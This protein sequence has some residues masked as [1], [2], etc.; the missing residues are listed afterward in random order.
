M[1]IS[2]RFCMMISFRTSGNPS[3]SS[4]GMLSGMYRTTTAGEPFWRKALMRKLPTPSRAK[5]VFISIS[6]SYSLTW[7]SV[8]TSYRSWLTVSGVIMVWLT[9]TSWPLILMLI[10]APT[11]MK[12]SDAFL[13]AMI[14]NSLFIADISAPLRLHVLIQ[15]HCT[16]IAPE[17]I[18]QAGLGARL[19]VDLFYYHRTIQAV[20]A[21]RR[22]NTSGNHYRA[23]RHPAV[24]DLPGGAVQDA[25]ALAEEDA[26]GNDAVL[27]D[28]DAFDHLRARPDEAVVLD[29]HRI[30]LHRLEHAA[31]SHAARQVHVLADLGAGAHRRPGID[32][33]AFIDVGPDIDEGGHEDDVLRDVGAS[34][35]R[36]RRDDTE[37]ALLE[38][39][40]LEF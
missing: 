7:R 15:I 32:H 21:A 31:D 2:P 25:G 13:S 12:M 10:G 33:R 40:G 34:P 24:Q 36:G 26:H 29:D 16:L 20:F 28:D 14:W 9:G 5:A 4:G 35:G 30:G 1:R 3:E 37:A 27:L 11:E 39:E 17:K 18:V 38:I 8:R 23:G 6:S 19:G 22:G